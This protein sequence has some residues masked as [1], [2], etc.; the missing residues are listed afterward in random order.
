MTSLV[1]VGTRDVTQVAWGPFALS[2]TK[3]LR[4]VDYSGVWGGG[5]ARFSTSIALAFLFLFSSFSEVSAL[6]ER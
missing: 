6:S 3:A 4:R 2:P 5:I 1:T